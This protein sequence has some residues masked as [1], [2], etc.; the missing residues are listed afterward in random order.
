MTRTP[1]QLAAATADL[2]AHLARID[3][4][5]V[6]PG[7][8]VRPSLAITALG[9]AAVARDN[10]RAAVEDAEQAV[11]DAVREARRAGHTWAE[12]ALALGVRRQSA[13]KRYGHLDQTA[14]AGS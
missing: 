4:G 5:E 9:H 6:E 12:V 3:A 7:P 10:A 1:E 8:M 13:H 14:Q 2:D 11:E